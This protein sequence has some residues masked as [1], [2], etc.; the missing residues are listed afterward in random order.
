MG[1]TDDKTVLAISSQVVYGS[2]G[3]S[4][5]VP[6]LESFG[7]QVL[8]VPTVI[9]ASRPGLGTYTALEI[10]SEDLGSFLLSL[11]NDGWFDRI[12]GILTGYFLNPEQVRLVAQTITLIKEKRKEVVYVCDP[13]LG[14]TP[15]GLYVSEETGEALKS[16]LLPI[17]DLATPNLFEACWLAD[18]EPVATID[19]NGLKKLAK[20]LNVEKH[21][22]TSA[23]S[24]RRKINSAL[25]EGEIFRIIEHKR[26]DDVPKGIGDAF[27]ALMLANILKSPTLEIAF[28][29]SLHQIEWLAEAASGDKT[30]SAALRRHNRSGLFHKSD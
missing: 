14:D 20:S 11:R 2:V 10:R 27:S 5:A 7:I 4:I 13:V 12:S 25:S 24:T 18:A 29:N 28:E 16:Q 23:V 22:I 8:P 1:S 17:A 19:T 30:L 21:V 15:E 9:L 3:L 6:C 26:F